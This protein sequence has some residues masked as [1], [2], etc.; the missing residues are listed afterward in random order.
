MHIQH[1]VI[2]P[3]C[4]PY[5]IAELGVNH[6]GSRERAVELVAAAR[7]ARA[8][9]IK[10]QCFD[11]NAL[12]SQDGTLAA[13]QRAT[14]A[15]SPIE[16]LRSLQLSLSDMSAIVA[17]AHRCG[18]HAIV[19]VFNLDLVEVCKGFAWD[20]FKVASPDII[21]QPLIEALVRCGKPMIISTGAATAEEVRRAS[22]WTSGMSNVSF[23]QCVSAYPVPDEDAALAGI[24]SVHDITGRV[25]GYSDHTVS[26]DTGALAVAAGASILEK[27]VTRDRNASGPDHSASIEPGDFAE[28]VRQ[29]RRAHAMLG[30]R[31]KAVL[32]IE[33]DVRHVSRQSLTTTR[34]INRGDRLEPVDIAIK[35]PGGGIEP[36]RRDEIIGRTAA[37]DLAPNL[38]LHEDDLDDVQ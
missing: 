12:Y 11:P 32:D 33:Q 19:T 16:M 14:H 18:L 23:L 8:D 3:D 21:N 29:V 22:H 6:D 10:L 38:M 5:V 27:H 30:T 7:E 28:Y 24:E 4:P 37:R 35:R 25:A 13:Y 1:R 15:D 2:G 31:N 20:A 34:A 9:A 36:W 17:E 26:V